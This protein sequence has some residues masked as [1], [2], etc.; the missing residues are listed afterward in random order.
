MSLLGAVVGALR[1]TLSADTA[2]FQE[3]LK[4]AGTTLKGSMQVAGKVMTAFAATAAASFASVAA[5]AVATT[6]QMDEVAKSAQKIGVTT[7]ELSK[8][9]YAA[10]LSG[11]SANTLQQAMTRLNVAIANSATASSG[12]GKALRE[13]GVT[14]GM[15]PAQALE[16]IAAQFAAMPDGARKSALAVQIFGRSGAELIPLLNQG[17]EGLQA[18]SA[19]AERLGLVIDQR[20]AAAAEKF[21]DNLTRLGKVKE[22]ILI[23]ITTGLVPAFSALTDGLVRSLNVADVW[24]RAGEWLG[25]RLLDL[26]EIAVEAANAFDVLYTSARQAIT[27]AGGDLSGAQAMGFDAD[28]RMASRRTA[29]ARM[30][31][32]VRWAPPSFGPSVSQSLEMASGNRGAAGG[33]GG[34]GR[35]GGGGAAGRSGGGLAGVEMGSGGTADALTQQALWFEQAAEVSRRIGESWDRQGRARLNASLA[36]IAGQTEGIWQSSLEPMRRAQ[37]VTENIASNL[38][39]AIVYGQDIGKALISSFKAVLAEQATRTIFR[40]LS[41]LTTK[42]FGSGLFAGFF[43]GGGLVPRGKWGI[44]GEAGPEMV[45]AGTSGAMVQP[46]TGRG[47]AAGPARGQP[48]ALRVTVDAAP[49]LLVRVQQEGARSG[50]AGGMAAVQS[51]TRPRLPRGMGA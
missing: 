16:K 44:V 46:L 35:T 6:K 19:E 15:G 28:R 30:R 17:A 12:A 23:Q 50:V 7:E 42:V 11:V 49:E 36:Q 37:A 32:D 21:Q 10:E 4:Q 9:R 38:A 14:A 45:M 47:A 40:L 41:G 1:I 33:G 27:F 51:V 20:A 25:R 5:A 2:K 48:V 13:L 29:I 18:M 3:G 8:L 34:N 26:A 22:G 31:A 24:Q 43:A 39:Q